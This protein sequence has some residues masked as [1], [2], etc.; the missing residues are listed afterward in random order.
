MDMEVQ[1]A[2]AP[3]DKSLDSMK[4]SLEAMDA[5]QRSIVEK[6]SALEKVVNAVLE[7]T[8]WVR[9]D[10]RVVHEVVVKLSN[11]VSVLSNTVA[12]VEG[13][14][15][16]KSPPVSAWGSW[17]ESAPA[18]NPSSTVPP[19][20][21]EDSEVQAGDEERSLLHLGHDGETLIQETQMY[22][23]NICMQRNT[24]SLPEEIE[25]GGWD[26]TL[27]TGRTLSLPPESQPA[28][29]DEDERVLAASTQ[30]EMTIDCTQSATQ[31][32]GRSIWTDLVTTVRD[33]AGSLHKGENSIEGWVTSKRGRPSSRED[34][35]E[36]HVEGMLQNKTSHTNLNLNLSPEYSDMR[37]TVRGSG[38]NSATRGRGAG[39]RG[40]GR[41]GGRGAGRGKRPPL[42]QPRYATKV[43]SAIAP[44]TYMH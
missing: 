16:E 29:D 21:G 4:V 26:K 19:G 1:N 42:V 17:K 33:M 40:G 15:E 12:M 30:V 28:G 43:S 13:V 10:V 11:H 2:D 41:G 22:D 44:I 5:T 23:N 8:S 20:I 31:A 3:W 36:T 38:Q 7:D 37:H 24:M 9:G 34:G 27:Y 18:P 39:S 14:P 32:P 35:T 25:D 6:L